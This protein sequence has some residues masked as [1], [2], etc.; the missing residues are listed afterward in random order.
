MPSNQLTLW[1]STLCPTFPKDIDLAKEHAITVL[2]ISSPDYPKQLK[3]LADAPP[4]LYVKGNLPPPDA[5]KVAIV[6]TRNATS[7][8]LE[9]TR[10]FAKE[11]AN[12]GIWIISGLARGIDTAAHTSSLATTC[13]FIGSGLLHIYPQENRALADKICVMSEYPLTSPPTR[14]TFPKRNRL[15]SAFSDA[16]LLTEAPIKSG[17]MITMNQGH[18]QQK[19]L[20]TV[21]GRALNENY[22]GNH[23]LL[24]QGKAKLVETPAELAAH[25]GLFG[26]KKVKNNI[27]SHL[28]S[29]QE[30]KILDILYQSEV[31][32]DELSMKCCLSI[33]TLQ[34]S[35]TKLILKK[36]A[37][38]LPG[39]RYKGIG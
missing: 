39:K 15:I 28:I 30:Q 18:L 17:A 33:A 32:L 29:P 19:P 5:I 31:S 1:D 6:G 7:W 23:L 4:F 20:F 35:L 11:L 37:V 24:K 9:C 36:M 21:P 8:G 14:Y 2:P 10:T 13:A 27:V 16:I 25:L 22:G 34:V 12:L 3:Q 26:P 38:E